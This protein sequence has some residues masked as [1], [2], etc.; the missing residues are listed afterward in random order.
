MKFPERFKIPSLKSQAAAAAAA[1][2]II[3]PVGAAGFSK[4]GKLI[5]ISTF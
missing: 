4:G 2:F 3:T 1:V 5:C